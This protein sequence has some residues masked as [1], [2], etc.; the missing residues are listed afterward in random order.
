MDIFL[1]IVKENKILWNSLNKVNFGVQRN[2]IIAAVMLV[3]G[4]GGAVLPIGN[5]VTLSATAFS[6]VVGIVL[7]LVLPSEE[8]SN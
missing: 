7:N 5:I 8:K 1:Q 4:I 6:A 2:L 3:I